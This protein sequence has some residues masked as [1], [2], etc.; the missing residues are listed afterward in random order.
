[1][2]CKCTH[3]WGCRLRADVE[4][5][6]KQA[7]SVATFFFEVPHKGEVVDQHFV[8]VHAAVVSVG[9]AASVGLGTLAFLN[10]HLHV[11]QVP[12]GATS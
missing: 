2:G 8:D 5:F 3:T 6:A 10:R 9:V 7:G 4:V 1:M 11:V 12:F